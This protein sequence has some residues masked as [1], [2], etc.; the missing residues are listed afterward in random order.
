MAVNIPGLISVIVFYILILIVGVVAGR[1]KRSKTVVGIILADRNMSLVVSLFTIT[2]TWIGGGFINGTAEI[3]AKKGFAWMQAPI[4]YSLSLI[5]GGILF[6]PRLRRDNCITM[7]DPFQDRY[8]GV[9]GA[10]MCIPQFLGDLFWTAAILSALGSTMAIILDLDETL[11]VIISAIISVSYTLVGGLWSVAYTDIVQLICLSVGLVV[12]APFIMTNQAVD[13]QRIQETW[14]GEVTLQQ[15]G[16]FLDRYGL[17]ILGGTTWQEM[18]QRTL[19]CRT[20]RQA[21]ASSVVA[22]VMCLL[23]SIPPAVIGFAGSAADWNQTGY[24]GEIPLTVEQMHFILPM[25][26]Q[27]LCPMTVSILGLG[28]VSAAVMSSTDSSTLCTA[29]V[30]TKNIYKSIIRKKALDREMVWVMRVAIV[31]TGALAAVIAIVVKSVYGLFILCSDLMYVILFP[32]FICVLYISSCNAYGSFVGFMVAFILRACSGAKL[33]NF[34]AIIHYPLYNTTDGQLF[35]FRT[36]IAV[37]GFFLIISVSVGT[38]LLFT[39]GWI[40]RKY[41]IFD[42]FGHLQSSDTADKLEASEML[43]ESDV[44]KGKLDT[45]SRASSDNM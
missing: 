14:L 5:I 16:Y 22:G 27:Y 19:A 17:L 28:A 20:T 30:F 35:P 2:A 23:L 40:S 7:L 6:C 29:S 32:Q 44:K 8:G 45:C 1:K 3:V 33:I 37:I 15:T 4:G 34:P 11:S 36:L 31:V 18:Y 42:C 21:V 41:D 39:R 13:L 12:A 25:A 26:L 24:M 43:P 10:L 38:K 9:M